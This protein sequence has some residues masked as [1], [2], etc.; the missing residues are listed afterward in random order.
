MLSVRRECDGKRSGHESATTGT[1][2]IGQVLHAFLAQLKVGEQA[3]A[4]SVAGS[5]LSE[6]TIHL[7]D[8]ISLVGKLTCWPFC[9]ALH[10]TDP[11]SIKL[12][13]S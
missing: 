10:N 9:A 7:V 12:T 3:W 4:V 8:S 13:E 1:D 2:D 5:Q 11:G 6:Y